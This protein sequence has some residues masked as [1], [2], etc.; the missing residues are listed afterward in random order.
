MENLA[1]ALHSI[2]MTASPPPVSPPAKSPTSK[3]FSMS[4]ILG[5]EKETSEED[6]KTAVTPDDALT[7]LTQQMLRGVNPWFANPFLLQR[8]AAGMY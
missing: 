7:A 1:L 6:K 8:M 2:D 5:T 3:S 4:R